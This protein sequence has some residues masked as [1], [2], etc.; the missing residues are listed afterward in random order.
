MSSYAQVAN[1]FVHGARQASFQG[2]ANPI[3]DPELQAGLDAASTLADDYIGPRGQLPLQ[4]PY[5][6]SLVIAVCQIAAYEILS[7]RGLNPAANGDTN[8]RDR[9]DDAMRWLEQVRT[10]QISPAFV[11]SPEVRAN[12]HQQPF[13]SS[14]SRLSPITG[15]WAKNRGW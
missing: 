12:A 13:V 2:G 5:P 3:S 14:K 7:V 10:Q 4:L 1:L 8:L 9:R 15:G 6:P 11:F